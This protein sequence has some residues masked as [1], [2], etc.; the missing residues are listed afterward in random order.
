MTQ[1]MKKEGNVEEGSALPSFQVE[2]VGLTLEAGHGITCQPR[3]GL[4]PIFRPIPDW[5]RP[6]LTV[7][8]KG[9]GRELKRL[10]R[11]RAYFFVPRHLLDQEQTWDLDVTDDVLAGLREAGLL[12]QELRDAIDQMKSTES[13]CMH[14]DTKAVPPCM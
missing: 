8:V 6:E 4:D 12:T 1:E 5:T 9:T 2:V 10:F 7:Q 14:S 3:E 13:S 11:N